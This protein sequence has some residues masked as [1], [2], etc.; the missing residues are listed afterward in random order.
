MKKLCDAHGE[1]AGTFYYGLLV[2]R[3]NK[4][5]RSIVNELHMHPRSLDR[6]LQ[7]I[8]EPGIALTLTDSQEP[9]PPLHV[10]L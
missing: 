1:L 4:S 8:V 2:S 3:M 6:K 5:K 10:Q 7:K 9:L